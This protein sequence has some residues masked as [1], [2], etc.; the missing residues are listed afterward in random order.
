MDDE[1]YKNYIINRE[2][3][4]KTIPIG[5]GII[6][7]ALNININ[8]K[9]WKIEETNFYE[10]TKL[11]ADLKL[12]NVLTGDEYMIGYRA[13]DAVKYME[14]YFLDMTLRLTNKAGYKTEYAKI[15]EGCG[16]FNFYCFTDH[17]KIVKWVFVNLESF[18][19]AHLLDTKTGGW[20]PKPYVSWEIRSNKNPN[21]T[22]FIVYDMLSFYH[23]DESLTTIDRV[24]IDHSP[25]YIDD[26]NITL[27]PKV[28][29][30][31]IKLCKLKRKEDRKDGY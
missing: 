28:D 19:G 11:S 4:D 3:S 21:D 31:F 26:V 14:K 18:R 15:M 17:K 20:V 6:A 16:D 23:N 7:K 27:L 25:G 5:I 2:W 10:D 12:T 22:D 13:R 1:N 29:G 8:G 30:Q 9:T 24:I